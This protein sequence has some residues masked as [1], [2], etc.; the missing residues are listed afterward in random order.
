[1]DRLNNFAPAIGGAA[2]FA[3]GWWVIF[4]IKREQAKARETKAAE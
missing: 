3:Y 2:I 1:M 4:R